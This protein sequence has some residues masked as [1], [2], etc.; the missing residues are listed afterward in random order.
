M[1]V[2]NPFRIWQ[3]LHLWLKNISPVIIPFQAELF[4]HFDNNRFWI[5]NLYVSLKCKRTRKLRSLFLTSLFLFQDCC[6][7]FC[8]LQIHEESAYVDKCRESVSPPYSRAFLQNFNSRVFLED[9]FLT[10]GLK[11]G[12]FIPGL[13]SKN[14]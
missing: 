12:S 1:L 13:D 7:Y 11:V 5:Y 10:P 6:V 4:S 3:V 14:V 9:Y 8:M 2:K